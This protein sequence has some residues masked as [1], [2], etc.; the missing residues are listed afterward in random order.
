MLCVC[1]G[2]TDHIFEEDL[3]D[4]SGFFVDKSGD[5]LD[6]T[7]AGETAD[8]GLSYALDV[9]PEDFAMSLGTTFA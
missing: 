8:C 6:T 3:E 7:S 2:I 1:H 5:T 4:T 9:V